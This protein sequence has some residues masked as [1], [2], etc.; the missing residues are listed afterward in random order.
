MSVVPVGVSVIIRDADGRV[1]L[2]LRKGKHGA[3]TWCCPGGALE[4][5]ESPEAC[6]CREVFE[7]TGLVVKSILVH[8]VVP[9]VSTMFEDGQ[10]WIT[11]YFEAEVFP[12]APRLTEPDKCERW[13]WFDP[14]DLPSPLFE[15]LGDASMLT[16]SER[17]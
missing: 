13:E 8:Q 17:P 16:N 1:L 11:L 12:G 3:G 2:G 6:A 10:Q 7:E 15:S 5:G 14:A 4:Y 9:Y